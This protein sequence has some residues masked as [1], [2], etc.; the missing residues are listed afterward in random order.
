MTSLEK[1]L[2]N[3]QIP[4]NPNLPTGTRVLPLHPIALWTLGGVPTVLV[5][6]DR[7]DRDKLISSIER[8]S[9][10]WP[11]IAGRYSRREKDGG[12]WAYSVCSYP[13]RVELNYRSTLLLRR[14]PWRLRSCRW[15]PHFPI[16]MW[17]NRH[18]S[19][20][21]Q[22]FLPSTYS[23]PDTDSHLVAFRL[24][25]LNTFSVLGVAW[26]HVL[27][28]G[29][30]ASRFLRDLSSIYAGHPLGDPPSFFPHIHLPVYPP[31]PNVLKCYDTVYLQARDKKELFEA[32]S[33]AKEAT[34]KV[35]L[36]LSR[37]EVAAIKAEYGGHSDQDA[38]SAWWIMLIDRTS[39][40]PRIQRA[41]YTVNVRSV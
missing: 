35:V 23:I 21:F 39:S 9:A 31:P 24:T 37:R 22:F 28:D 18:L 41:I 26:A 29:A 5:F 30:T 34:E 4:S 38:I 6:P 8:V 36:R 12:G 2:I 40:G 15:T 27:G 11:N 20:I 10:L 7:I 25:H 33:A 19:R 17:F 13:T 1:H 16:S 32:Y 14:F 3:P